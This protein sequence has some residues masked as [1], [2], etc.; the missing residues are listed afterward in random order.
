M[1]SGRDLGGK[2]IVITGANTGIGLG[3]AQE[4]AD[5]G[6]RLRLLCRSAEKTLPVIEELKR[7][8]GHDDVHFIPC[9]LGKLASVRAA[10]ATLLER[11]EP[12]H[13]LINNA[14]VAGQR[15]Q[16]A[17]GFEL[18]FGTNHM[19]HFVLTQLLTERLKRS[20]PARIVSLS[21]KANYQ[22]RG[23]DWEAVRR[24]TGSWSALPEYAVSKLCNVLFTRELARRLEGTQVTSYAVHPGV[25]ASDIWKR[26]PWGLRN[27][28]HLFMDKV[29]EGKRS[30]IL[31]ATAPELAKESGQYY[32]KDGSRRR[33]NRL[34]DDEQLAAELWKRSEAWASELA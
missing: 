19:G 4:L 16:T 26:I 7:R 29:E 22:A 6:A 20:A 13:V 18:A 5:R 15:G 24:P 34:A 1:S 14:G 11:D 27:L 23:I 3:T 21:S 12:L 30:T 17:D 9:D 31:T 10:A 2:V 8:A 25:I 28:A 33:A 32:D